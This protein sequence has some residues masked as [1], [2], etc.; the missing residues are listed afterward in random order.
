MKDIL[1]CADKLLSRVQQRGPISLSYQ[2]MEQ[3]ELGEQ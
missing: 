3:V 2:K 1:I